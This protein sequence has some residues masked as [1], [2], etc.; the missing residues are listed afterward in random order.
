MKTAMNFLVLLAACCL[1]GCVN[2]VTENQP[3]RPPAYRDRVE[4]R[5]QKSVDEV[6]DASKRALTSF[7]NITAEGKVFAS[8]NQVRVVEGVVNG[9]QVYMRVEEVDAQVTAAVVQVR[10][11]MGGTDLRIAKDLV[12][13]IAVELN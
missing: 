8:T 1:V 5:Y 6:F 9:R 13:R 4:A 3:G 2:T 11:K 12:Q 10:T 7:G